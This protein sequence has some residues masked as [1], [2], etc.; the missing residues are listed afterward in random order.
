[1][2]EKVII[3]SSFI[4]KRLC[5]TLDLV[6]KH[7]MG[8]DYVCCESKSGY[9][10]SPLAKFNYSSIRLSDKEVFMPPQGLLSDNG[11]SPTHPNLFT[12]PMDSPIS[13]TFPHDLL[14]CIFYLVTR[15]EEYHDDPKH[16]DEHGRFIAHFSVA[17]REGFLDRPIVNLWIELIKDELSLLFPYLIFKKHAYAYLPTYDI[18]MAWRYKHKGLIR[19]MGGLA[20]D[21]AQGKFDEVIHRVKTLQDKACDPDDTFDYI[22]SLTK[23]FNLNPIYFWLLSD[24]KKPFDINTHF[25][26]PALR[27]LIQTISKTNKVGIHPGYASNTNDEALKQEVQ[28]LADIL[29]VG[30]TPF[31]VTASRQHFLK[32]KFPQTYRRLLTLGIKEDYTMGYADAIGFRAGI[33]SPF[34]WYDLEREETTDLMVHPFQVMDVTLLRYLHFSPNEAINKTKQIIQWVKM[35]GGEFCTLW[36]NTSLCETNEWHGW[37][38]VYEEIIRMAIDTNPTSTTDHQSVI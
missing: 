24:Y 11:I 5:Y 13:N 18:D 6:F 15:Y 9:I 29:S 21:I 28:R 38:K 23:R 2:S 1:M 31:R 25:E 33:A 16:F 22:F 17:H 35:T 30:T 10:E 20:R 12:S 26:T 34:Y 8:L 14:S 32:L 19:L 3:Y 36:H 27:T 4:S 7:N 37:R